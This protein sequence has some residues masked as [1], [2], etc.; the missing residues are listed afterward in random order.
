MSTEAAL[1]ALRERIE[2]LK[3]DA[4]RAGYRGLHLVQ[5]L[6]ID[7]M[8]RLYLELRGLLDEIWFKSGLYTGRELH[9]RIGLPSQEK[10]YGFLPLP[11][12]DDLSMM[13]DEE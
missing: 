2:S 1:N 5:A 13:R 8:Y 9:D 10:V 6:Y 4:D 3:A 7:E 12:F 11:S